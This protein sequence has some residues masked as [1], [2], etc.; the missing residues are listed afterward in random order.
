[1]A[2]LVRRTRSS[3]SYSPCLDLGFDSSSATLWVRFDFM[4]PDF[5]Y[6]PAHRLELFPVKPVPFHVSREFPFPERGVGLR[7]RQRMDGA[8]VPEAPMDE[9][10]DSLFH[11]DDVGPARKAVI[12]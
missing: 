6:R 2:T 9:D 3:D 11:V 4:L 1:M 8:P 12:P 10:Y 5:H 7:R